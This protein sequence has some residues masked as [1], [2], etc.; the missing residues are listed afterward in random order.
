MLPLY[1][2]LPSISSASTRFFGQPKFINATFFDFIIT[3]YPPYHYSFV[4]SVLPSLPGSGT[5]LLP[6]CPYILPQFHPLP[7]AQ[8]IWRRVN[9][10]SLIFFVKEIQ[11]PF[12]IRALF[13]QL[14]YII[15]PLY[16]Y[17]YRLSS[18]TLILD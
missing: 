7:S 15:H 6:D 1:A 4:P 16:C 8:S 18:N 17:L 9:T 10:Q 14:H 2:T 12:A 13:S 5:L 3:C 11:N